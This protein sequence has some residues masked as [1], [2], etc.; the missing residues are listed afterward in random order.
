M[1]CGIPESFLAEKLK[2][3][4]NNLA[5]NNLS[6]AYLPQP[7]II[8]LRI[9]AN[10]NRLNGNK[11]INNAIYKLKNIIPENIFAV[12]D[13]TFEEVIGKLLTKKK[14][15]VCAAESCTGGYISHLLTSVPGSSNYFTGSVIAYSNSVKTRILKVNKQ[16]IVNY[17]AVSKQVVLQMAK[18]IRN[19]FNTDFSIAVSGIAGPN[20][21]TTEKPVGT[22][23]IT[24]ASEKN[25]FTSKFMFGND[26]IRNIIRASVCALDMLRKSIIY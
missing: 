26:R 24:I 18:N 6:L 10:Q 13:T 11:L 15:T 9:T 1:T 8:R 16:D 19:I 17:G 12:G 7:G 5:V 25:V 22:V 23:W 4:E 3:W 14:K 21:G 20:G 2:D